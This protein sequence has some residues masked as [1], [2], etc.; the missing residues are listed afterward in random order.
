MDTQRSRPHQLGTAAIC[1]FKQP[2]E[3]FIYFT[4]G[5]KHAIA[6]LTWIHRRSEEPAVTSVKSYWKKS[7]LSTVGTSIQ[8]MKSKEFSKREMAH[9]PASDGS[10]LESVLAES[11][12]MES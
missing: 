8:F 9:R 1:R 2:F 10:F 6:L 5:C 3:L 12:H 4:G 7:R 11:R